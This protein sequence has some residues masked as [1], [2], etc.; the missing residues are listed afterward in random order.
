[1]INLIYKEV[2][3]YYK[4][5]QEELGD[6]RLQEFSKVVILRTVDRK[7]M[8]HIDAM[9]HLRQGIHLR[10]YGQNSPLREYQMEGFA[11]F[12]EMV[13]E[14]QEEIVKYIMK[15]VVSEEEEIEREEVAINATATSGSQS[16]TQEVKKTAGS[17]Y[18]ESRS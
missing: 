16:E 8:D 6:E 9:E 1:M 3:K 4:E 2:K 5:K 11:M 17:P 15:S 7:W 18:G 12:E 14:I 10:A 13:E